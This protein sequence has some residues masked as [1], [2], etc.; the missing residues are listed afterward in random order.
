MVEMCALQTTF[1]MLHGGSQ[2][3]SFY[4]KY[5]FIGHLTNNRRHPKF[6]PQSPKVCLLFLFYTLWRSFHFISIDQQELQAF[7]KYCP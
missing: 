4:F 1:Y 3:C 6:V 7:T 2:S 5:L